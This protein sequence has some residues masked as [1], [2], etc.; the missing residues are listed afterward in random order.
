MVQG[1]GEI[2]RLQTHVES[3]GDD[4]QGHCGVCHA[5]EGGCLEW[6]STNNVTT[7]LEASPSLNLNIIT[8]KIREVGT[9]SKR[10]GRCFLR[11][12]WRFSSLEAVLCSVALL[13]LQIK[14][15]MK[16]K[17]LK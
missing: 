1:R 16:L 15:S 14:P 10:G 2:R 7:N 13:N 4:V 8:T 17:W 3:D 9:R 6:K 11:R 12:R 5:A